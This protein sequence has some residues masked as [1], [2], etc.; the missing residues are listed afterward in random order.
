[1]MMS[2]NVQ[3]WMRSR[4]IAGAVVAGALALPLVGFGSQVARVAADSGTPT[5]PVCTGYELD[6]SGL[7]CVSTTDSPALSSAEMAGIEQALAL[8][9]VVLPSN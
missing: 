7:T 5:P 1:M 8:T 9:P 4:V 2:R 3:H 6:G